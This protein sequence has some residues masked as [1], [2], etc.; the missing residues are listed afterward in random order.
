MDLLPSHLCA[1]RGSRRTAG[2]SPGLAAYFPVFRQSG[3]ARCTAPRSRSACKRRKIG[4]QEHLPWP[5][6][7]IYQFYSP[8]FGAPAGRPPFASGALRFRRS[9]HTRSGRANPYRATGTPRTGFPPWRTHDRGRRAGA[10]GHCTR[11]SMSRIPPGLSFTSPWRLPLSAPVATQKMWRAT[12]V[13]KGSPAGVRGQGRSGA[14]GE[15]SNLRGIFHRS[16]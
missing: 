1:P 12:Q 3:P 11:N 10:A 2:K 15:P 4:S 6:L 8:V 5:G 14:C 16:G 7:A 13:Y 9:W